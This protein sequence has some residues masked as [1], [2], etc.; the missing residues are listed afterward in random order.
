MIL[1]STIGFSSMP[2]L[3]MWSDKILDI[4]FWGNIQDGRHLAKVKYSIGIIFHTI[5]AGAWLWCLF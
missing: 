4:A 3:V 2:D 1:V 5:E